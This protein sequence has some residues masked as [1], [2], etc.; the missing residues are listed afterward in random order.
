MEVQKY[1]KRLNDFKTQIRKENNLYKTALD[2]EISDFKYNL[3]VLGK[4]AVV[5]GGVL[6]GTVLLV[7]LLGSKKKQGNETVIV[8]PKKINSIEKP[9]KESYF[10]RIIKEQ[11]ALAIVSVVK[12]QINKLTKVEQKRLEQKRNE[13]TGKTNIA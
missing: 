9:V 13:L 11:L 5:T 1:Q 3:H 8:A 4:Y 2:H 12:G 7:K 10:S 6:A